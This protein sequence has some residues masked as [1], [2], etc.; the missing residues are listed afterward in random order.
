M[1]VTL[2][3]NPKTNDVVQL[4][5]QSESWLNVIKNNSGKS[6]PCAVPKKYFDVLLTWGLVD[7]THGAAKLSPAGLTWLLGLEMQAKEDAKKKKH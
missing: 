5:P 1:A 6:R 3:L 7:G 4:D 2:N